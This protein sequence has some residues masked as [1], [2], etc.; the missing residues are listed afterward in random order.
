MNK[1]HTN[2]ERL[3]SS[4]VIPL[5]VPEMSEGLCPL[6][7]GLLEKKVT[8]DYGYNLGSALGTS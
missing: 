6:Q 5:E 3:L 1:S 7:E 2:Q 4:T 8:A